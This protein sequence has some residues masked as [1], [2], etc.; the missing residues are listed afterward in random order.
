MKTGKQT[1]HHLKGIRGR[2]WMGLVLLAFGALFPM[3]CTQAYHLNPTGA[4]L[5]PTATS[6][7][8]GSMTATPIP[9]NTGTPTVTATRTPAAQPT[10]TVTA[11][12]P[13]IVIMASIGEISGASSPA[14]VQINNGTSPVTNAV[15]TLHTPAGSIPVTYWQ[16]VEM[17]YNGVTM[18]AS[19]YLSGS[20]A[21]TP[22]DVYSV[23][24]SYGGNHYSL[25]VTAVGG[26]QEQKGSTGVTLSWIGG[27]SSD[28]AVVSGM[29]GTSYY[30]QTYG[31]GIT[32]PYSIPLSDFPG[33]TSTS[34]GLGSYGVMLVC[35]QTSTY[36]TSGLAFEFVSTDMESY[37]Y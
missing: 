37:T 26:A 10:A 32:S 34:W 25:A 35:A 33:Y 16:S 14:E 28:S 4:V 29:N 7:P 11:T 9:A 23:D 3:A 24:V 18:T 13:G 8:K 31:P 6:T 2:K 17:T 12:P 27:G 19:G 15:I 22:G 30:V 20:Y 36:A 5:L 21:Y 1:N